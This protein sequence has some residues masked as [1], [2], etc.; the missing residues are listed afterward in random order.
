MI[1]A[2]FFD[3]GETLVDETRQW[4]EWADWLHVTRLTFF[5]CLGAVIARGDHHRRVFDLVAPGRDIAVEDISR[6]A[7]G[8]T[9]C[10]EARDFYPDALPALAACRAAGLK[11]GIAGNQPGGAVEAMLAAGIR[12]DHL[13]SSVA[14]GVAKPDP[15]FFARIVAEAGIP[16]S[17]IAYV[18]DRLD[19]V[20]LPAR[21]VGMVG[22]LVQ[23]GPWG[24]LHAA[25]DNVAQ[26]DAVIDSLH[27]LPALLA[28]F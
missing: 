11:V 16:A 2:V 17:G 3:V 13:A 22:I 7:A 23:R 5:A 15:D 20:I 25:S 14:W 1:R 6:A 10:I 8:A 21:A 12:V 27:D 9:H 4:G 24:F 19:N 18:G 28:R 26:A